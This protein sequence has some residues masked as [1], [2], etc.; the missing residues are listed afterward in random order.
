MHLPE[1][2]AWR[3]AAVAA[4]E[5]AAALALA[6]DDHTRTSKTTKGSGKSAAAGKKP[7]A[8]KGQVQEKGQDKG[9]GQGQGQAQ[10]Q[11][12]EKGIPGI[13]VG[14]E[15][16]GGVSPTPP[17]VVPP[18]DPEPFMVTHLPLLMIH[19][20]PSPIHMKNLNIKL[21]S[22]KYNVFH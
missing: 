22:K 4:E 14:H 13:G 18:A 3:E 7:A 11:G 10:V 20:P 12:H 9:Q 15:E 17:L 1:E 5:A 21:I 8:G 16:G 19:S 6:S 2:K